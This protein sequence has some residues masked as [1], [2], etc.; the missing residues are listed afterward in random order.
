[1]FDYE[2]FSPK[3]CPPFCREVEDLLIDSD[4]QSLSESFSAGGAE[5]PETNDEHVRFILLQTNEN[6]ECLLDNVIMVHF[7]IP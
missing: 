1:M 2:L 5:V 3:T 7:L 6:Y 4:T